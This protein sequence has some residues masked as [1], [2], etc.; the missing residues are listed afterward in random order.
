MGAKHLA[1][2]QHTDLQPS[3]YF[4]IYFQ[5]FI[6]FIYD[7]MPQLGNDKILDSILLFNKYVYLFIGYACSFH[8]NECQNTIT[9]ILFKI[10]F[11]FFFSKLRLSHKLNIQGIGFNVKTVKPI[12]SLFHTFLFSRAIYVHNVGEQDSF[13]VYRKK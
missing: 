13:F 3:S 8:E 4:L 1:S 7:K 12:H 2:I 6:D 9:T 5:N 11:L 10:I